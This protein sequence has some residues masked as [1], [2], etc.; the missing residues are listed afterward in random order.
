MGPLVTCLQGK[1]AEVIMIS[2][3]NKILVKLLFLFFEH[4]I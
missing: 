3:K 4:N 2:E 1:L